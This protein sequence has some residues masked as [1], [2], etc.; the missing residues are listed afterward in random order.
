[1]SKANHKNVTLVA[2]EGE[3]I[4]RKTAVVGSGSGLNRRELFTDARDISSDTESGTLSDVEYYALLNKRGSEALSER[5]IV[6]AFDGEVEATR[7]YKYGRD[8]FIGD[9]VQIINEYGHE[10]SA[11]I[12]ELIFSQNENG[13]S[14]YPTFQTI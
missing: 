14:I 2:G 8:F 13:I 7:L 6:T 4:S 9:I 10:G 1:M 11:Y 12:S 5:I 3:G